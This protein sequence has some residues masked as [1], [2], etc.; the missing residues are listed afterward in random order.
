[1]E[2][3]QFLI[4]Q[5]HEPKYLASCTQYSKHTP[6]VSVSCVHTKPFSGVQINQKWSKSGNLL[7]F[8]SGS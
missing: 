2:N 7:T 6:K 3:N 5:N 1:M 4:L 8:S